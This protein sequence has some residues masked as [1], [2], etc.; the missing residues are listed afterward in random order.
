MLS[1]VRMKRSL[2]CLTDWVLTNNT[3]SANTMDAPKHLSA[4]SQ[5]VEELLLTEEAQV[6]DCPWGMKIW[7]LQDIENEIIAIPIES[8]SA[9]FDREYES[10]HTLR[11]FH[12]ASSY[13]HGVPRKLDTVNRL[14]RQFNVTTVSKCRRVSTKKIRWHKR[15][16][17]VLHVGNK[18]E[19]HLER[20]VLLRENPM[21]NTASGNRSKQ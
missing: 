13:F 18:D 17:T 3:I 2:F 6:D 15:T 4:K 10:P 1:N 21:A 20:S 8:S 19:D 5:R 11:R 12:S 14:Y 16:S 7:D 9:E